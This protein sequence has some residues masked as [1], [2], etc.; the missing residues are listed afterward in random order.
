MLWGDA[1]ESWDGTIM[2]DARVLHFWDEDRRV[3]SWFAEHVEGYRGI[4]WDTYYLYGPD[5]VWD[6]APLPLAGS[7]STIYSE[8]DTLEVQIRML[9]GQ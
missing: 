3:G 9:L 2:P 5:A 1:R 7:G 8:R 4:A 6:A